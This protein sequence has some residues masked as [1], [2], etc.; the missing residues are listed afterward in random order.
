MNQ[1][2]AFGMATL[3]ALATA[4]SSEEAPRVSLP[5]AADASATNQ[6]TATNL[7]YLVTLTRAR[8]ALRDLQF[9]VGG[10][11]HQALLQRVQRWI[12]PVAHA[13]PGHAGGGEVVGELPGKLLVDWMSDGSAMGAAVMLAGKYQGANFGFRVAEAGELPAGDPLIGHTF[14]FEG[15]ASKD[16]RSV[17]FTALVDVDP[18][19]TLI[20]APFDHQVVAGQAETLG[21]R[22]LPRNPTDPDDTIWNQIDFFALP[23]AEV[24]RARIAAPGEAHN[25]LVRALRTHDHYDVTHR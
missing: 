4:C 17:P 11:T 7:G 10:E 8:A 22:L 20:G 6:P 15:A 13:H 1:T 23:G 2:T 25:F 3:L 16:G 21:L 12:L 19:A 24:G 14:V 9:T 18:T 5:V